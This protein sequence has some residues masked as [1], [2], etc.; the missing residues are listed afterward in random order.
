MRP[1][2]LSL[3]EVAL[4]G[5][6]HQSQ[7]CSGYD[8]RKVMAHTPMGTFSDSPGAIYPALG[9]LEK[10]GFIH[11][12]VAETSALRRRKLYRLTE[13]GAEALQ[14]WLRKPVGRSD[15]VRGLRDLSLRFAFMESVLGPA[16]CVTFLEAL[17]SELADY[18]P[19]LREHAKAQKSNMPR[20]G[21]LALEGGILGYEAQL[22]WARMALRHYKRS[23]K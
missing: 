16:A 13:R 23:F 22:A 19:T 4:L 17:V 11:G 2:E 7:P 6:V 3:L 9:R 1:R 5:L 21:R 20:S 15:I 12:R 10:L 18:V 14:R 8:L